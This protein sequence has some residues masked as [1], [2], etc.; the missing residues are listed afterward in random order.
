M[1]GIFESQNGVTE[2]IVWYAW[3]SEE[4]ASYEKVGAG[5]TRHREAVEV[6]YNSELVSYEKLIEL[7]FTQ[8]DPTQSDG[9][10]ADRWYHYTTAI[11]T[12]D[13]E[14]RILATE[15]INN[16]DNSKKFDT[17]IAVKV[18][19]FTTFF[20]AEDYHQDYY[21]KSSLKYSL[22]KKWSG[23]EGYIE[24]TWGKELDKLTQDDLRKRLTPIQYK[25]TQE[26]WTEPPFQNEYND[27][28]R[29]GIYVDIVD[30]TPLYSSLDKYDSGT[31]WPSFTKP[32]DPNNISF[33]EDKKLWSTRIEVRSKYADSHLGHVFDDGPVDQGGKRY[34]MNS[35]AL[36][37]IPVEDLE[38]EGYG[39]WKSLFDNT[40]LWKNSSPL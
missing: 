32:I 18:E 23:R 20:P 31:G 21:K 35:A 11:Y 39:E 40:S 5:V 16:L 29:A 1:E 34:C 37:F 28:K 7:Y 2:A 22:Y 26:E 30:G 3:W 24:Q 4:D 14:E 33:K 17:P 36:R 10:F 19:D 6:T 12:Q 8:I 15:F 13:E 38:K 27:N 25:V 9:Q